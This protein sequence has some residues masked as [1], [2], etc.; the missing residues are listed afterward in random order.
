MAKFLLSLLSHLTVNN[1]TVKDSFSFVEEITT[2]PN[3]DEY[4]MASFDVTSLFTNIP[5]SE[6][7]R[8]TTNHLYEDDQHPAPIMR[9]AWFQQLLELLVKDVL[10][11]FNDEVFAQVDGVGM[12]NPLGPTFANIF[13]CHH[14]CIWLENCPTEFKPRMYRRYIDDVFLLFRNHDHVGKFLDYLNSK[15]PNIK[16]TCEIENIHNLAIYPL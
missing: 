1:Y 14:E 3:S 13:L 6:T 10:F 4:N 8:I 12:G 7:I 9:R 16:F 15:H 2:I 11:T 5:L